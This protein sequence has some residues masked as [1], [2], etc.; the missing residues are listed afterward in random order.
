[1]TPPAE[2]RGAGKRLH[3][4][5]RDKRTHVRLP[6]ARDSDAEAIDDLFARRANAGDQP[7]DHR[8]EPQCGA[9]QFLADEREPVAPPDVPQF[10]RGDRLTN[11]F[12][13]VAQPR[14]QKDHRASHAE[15][16]RL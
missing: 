11:V 13:G 1:M 9:D 4:G 7:P 3:I 14:G 16:H 12:R 2:R 10:V 6:A 15:H 8:L 5:E